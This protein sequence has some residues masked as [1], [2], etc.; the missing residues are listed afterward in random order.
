MPCL[1]KGEKILKSHLF[2]SLWGKEKISNEFKDTEK[3]SASGNKQ[4]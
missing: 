4:K 1:K 3:T 2:A